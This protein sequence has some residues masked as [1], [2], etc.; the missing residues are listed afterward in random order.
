MRGWICLVFVVASVFFLPLF[1][2]WLVGADPLE[3]RE[4]APEPNYGRQPE[5]QP[6]TSA[7]DDRRRERERERE[8]RERDQE[9]EGEE[10]EERDESETAP[11][12][13]PAPRGGFLFRWTAQIYV[14]SNFFLAFG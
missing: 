7:A 5:W 3:V 12:S 4:G 11:R 14:Y 2:G 13:G 1:L 9:E 8:R 10:G 6:G